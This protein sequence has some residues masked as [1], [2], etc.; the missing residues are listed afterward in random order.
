[1]NSIAYFL[2][3]CYDHD[4]I[5]TL[6][7]ELIRRGLVFLIP[8]VVYAVTIAALYGDRKKLIKWDFVPIVHVFVLMKKYFKTGLIAVPGLSLIM[9]SLF[10]RVMGSVSVIVKLTSDCF[11]YGSPM[12]PMNAEQGSLIADPRAC[13]VLRFSRFA[14]NNALLFAFFGLACFAILFVMVFL[15]Q[16]KELRRANSGDQSGEQGH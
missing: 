1:M 10:C 9:F 7:L 13:E 3:L 14:N 2:V 12:L 16:S 4:M 15:K 8:L 6:I 11:T 5:V